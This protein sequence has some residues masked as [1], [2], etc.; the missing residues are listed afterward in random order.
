MRDENARLP[1]REGDKGLPH[2]IYIRG[3]AFYSTVEPSDNGVE[4]AGSE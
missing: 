1:V 3:D 4:A 2:K